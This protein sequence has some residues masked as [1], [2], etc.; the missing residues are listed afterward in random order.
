MMV[1]EK[2]YNLRTGDFDQYK[3]ILPTSVLDIFQDIAGEHASI[4]GCDYP[5]LS[6]RGLMWVV[7]KT[8]FKI[9]NQPSIHQTV[10]VRTW[11]LKPSSVVYRRDYLMTAE[12]GTE[13]VRGTSDWVLMDVNERTLVSGINVYPDEEICTDMVMEKRA[14]RIPEIP[15]EGDGFEVKPRYT[16]MDMNGH[17]NN[18]KYISFVI[19]ALEPKEDDVF[20]VFQLEYHKELR[21]SDAARLYI[22]RRD[23]QVIARM[24]GD[25]GETRFSARFSN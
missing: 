8:R 12:D 15:T 7:V 19:D 21:R 6:P 20:T 5:Q 18:V 13:L 22:E 10:C 24:V 23:G 25:E 17:V 16:D 14:P 1:F 11:P 3:R 9:I 4:L 2:N